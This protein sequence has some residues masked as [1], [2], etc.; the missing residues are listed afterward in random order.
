VPLQILS[1]WKDIASYLGKGVRTVQRY[2][3]EL[4]LPIRRESSRS[5]IATV[6]ELEAWVTGSPIRK[7]FRL[8]D[9]VLNIDT[10]AQLRG[11][12]HEMSR[13][14]KETL[15]VR[16][17]LSRSLELLRKNIRFAMR[18]TR[19]AP[20]LARQCPSRL[21]RAGRPSVNPV[22]HLPRPAETQHPLTSGFLSNG[23]NLWVKV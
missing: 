16:H 5:V 17:A 13:L 14:R 18:G 8:T 3:C 11:N 19:S 1:G 10:R 9:P 7:Q 20:S 22:S 2:E 12:V 4:A 21:Q 23:S 15:L 6:D